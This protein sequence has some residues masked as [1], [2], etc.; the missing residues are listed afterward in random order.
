[1]GIAT[2]DPFDVAGNLTQNRAATRDL[3][4]DHSRS[5]ATGVGWNRCRLVEGPQT[6]SFDS[7]SPDGLINVEEVECVDKKT[8]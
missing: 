1:M 8:S 3:G 6:M 4:P 5:P 7:T 2:L